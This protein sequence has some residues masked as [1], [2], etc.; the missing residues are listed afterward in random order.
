[1]VSKSYNPNVYWEET[2]SIERKSHNG[3][4]FSTEI[5]ELYNY[6]ADILKSLKKPSQRKICY[7][8]F[9]F[10]K[11]QKQATL[12]NMLFRNGVCVCVYVVHV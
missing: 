12:I 11:V 2:K 10:N 3:I 7:R 5:N 6:M 9:H 1:M 8:I 4:P